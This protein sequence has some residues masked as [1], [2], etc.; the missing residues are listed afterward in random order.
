MMPD[1]NVYECSHLTRNNTLIS[2]KNLRERKRF[3]IDKKPFRM[4]SGKVDDGLFSSRELGRN[5]DLWNLEACDL[6]P[7]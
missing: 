7:T 2:E 1:R 6:M 3:P 5:A 4:I